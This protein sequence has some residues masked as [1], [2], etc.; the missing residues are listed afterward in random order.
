VNFFARE[1]NLKEVPP[2]FKWAADRMAISTWLVISALSVIGLGIWNGGAKLTDLVYAV[3]SI[4]IND[5]KQDETNQRQ[6]S[7]INRLELSLA[8]QQGYLQRILDAVE[9]NGRRMKP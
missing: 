9:S 8:Q 2:Q 1:P 6:D 4:K 7:Q 3:T 5:V